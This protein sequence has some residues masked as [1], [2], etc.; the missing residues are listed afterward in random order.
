MLTGYLLF[1]L[2][3][4]RTIIQPKLEKRSPSYYTPCS[5]KL[6]FN[7]L[8]VSP[9]SR[10]FCNFIDMSLHCNQVILFDIVEGGGVQEWKRIEG[11]YGCDSSPETDD[12]ACG[13]HLPVG[14]VT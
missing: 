12:E 2:I 4:L 3:C 11:D 10:M 9:I 1:S 14:I 8:R 13:S 6:P 5:D 7:A